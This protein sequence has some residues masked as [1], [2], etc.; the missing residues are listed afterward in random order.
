[1]GGSITT[2]LILLPTRGLEWDSIPRVSARYRTLGNKPFTRYQTHGNGYI[3]M[4]MTIEGTVWGQ[5]DTAPYDRP[6]SRV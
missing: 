5:K 1:M 2:L 6:S 4:Y 3:A